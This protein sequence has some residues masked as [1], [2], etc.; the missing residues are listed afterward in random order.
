MIPQGIVRPVSVVVDPP[1]GGGLP[2]LAEGPEQSTG[3]SLLAIRSI[4]AFALGVP[5]RLSGLDVMD[6]HPD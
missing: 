3:S 6:A 1:P 4:E 2:D 5:L